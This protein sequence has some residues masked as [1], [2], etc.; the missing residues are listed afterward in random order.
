M[1]VIEQTAPQPTPIPGIAHA[2][3]AGRDDGLTQLSLW[4]QRIDAGG[5]TPP[6]RHHC[7]EV[8]LCLSGEGE[9]HVGGVV[10]RFAAGRTVV[11]PKDRDHQLFSTGPGPLELI[12]VF[13]ATPVPTVL[14]DGSPLE[15]PWRS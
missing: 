7:D 5:A 6:H 4:R 10:H 9:V 2:T 8:V 3:W 14:P 13:A 15:L 12:G 11:L 1:S